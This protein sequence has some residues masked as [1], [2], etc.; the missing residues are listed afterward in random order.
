MPI[1]DYN[2]YAEIQQKRIEERVSNKDFKVGYFSPKSNEVN[3]VRFPYTSV[4]ELQFLDGCHMVKTASG[5]YRW[6]DCVRKGSKDTCPLCASGVKVGTRFICKLVEFVKD[7]QGNTV[8]KSR[9][10][11]AP[12]T[13]GEKLKSF[14]K[15]Y[16][17]NFPNIVFTIV[18]TGTGFDTKY[19]IE[20]DTD[21]LY[22]INQFSTDFVDF[23]DYNPV[24]H[25]FLTKS[26][27]EMEVFLQ[28]GEFPSTNVENTQNVGVQEQSMKQGYTQPQNQNVYVAPQQPYQS[29]QP[30]PYTQSNYQQPYQTAN[31]LNVVTQQPQQVN[32]INSQPR[33]YY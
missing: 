20:P 15:I 16:K 9:G 30:Q 23:V 31:G 8:A 24:G 32:P 22:N 12:K 2:T 7:E 5:N 11:L 33:K 27:E 14:I 1:F 18:K 21:G 3:V 13:V 28:T 6:V 19:D 17:N 10:W 26:V 25:L 4:E 29:V